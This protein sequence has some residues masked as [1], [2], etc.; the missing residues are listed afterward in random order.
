MAG[1]HLLSL[2]LTQIWAV[3]QL[4][5]HSLCRWYW[6][7]P[8]MS[9]KM[10]HVLEFKCP[11]KWVNRIKL[12]SQGVTTLPD[13]SHCQS[14]VGLGLNAVV[15]WLCESMVLYNAICYACIILFSVRYHSEIVIFNN[16]AVVVVVVR[17]PHSH[18][19]SINSQ[20][21]SLKMSWNFI[22]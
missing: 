6:Q 19:A 15:C 9:W 7:G 11:G 17:V 13:K 18:A 2:V 12:W 10:T 16:N 8:H 14:F 22:P 5:L 21:S 1:L 20:K 3:V 4:L